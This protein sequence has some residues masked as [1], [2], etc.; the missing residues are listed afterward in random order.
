[1]KN[2]IAVFLFA[3]AATLS[4]SAAEARTT[5]NAPA[6]AKNAFPE[7]MPE[8]LASIIKEASAT[9]GVDANL[10]AAVAVKESRFNALAVSRR[11]AQGLMQL[12]PRTA[13]AL[14]VKDSFDA[15]QNIFGGTK[16][17]AELLNR[18]D[19]DIDMALASYNLGPNRIAKEGP[20]ATAGVIDYVSD[21]K[22]FYN[23][24]LRAL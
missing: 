4:F 14:G 8:T 6:L 16:Y 5:D 1:M 15:R 7:R 21:I 12:M 3:I 22:S 13:K 24:A 19:G 20:R 9:Y 11:G 18:F 10:I 23:A 17:L 2:R